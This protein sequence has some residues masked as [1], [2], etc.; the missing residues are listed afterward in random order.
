MVG[1]AANLEHRPRIAREKAEPPD[2][3]Y[4]LLP[5]YW[6]MFTDAFAGPEK[7]MRL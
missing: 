1:D 7:C 5:I 6:R 4:L 2:Q 3:T